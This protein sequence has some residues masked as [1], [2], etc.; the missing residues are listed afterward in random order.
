LSILQI[1]NLDISYKE[2]NILKNVNL[3]VEENEIISIMG[4][5]GSGKSTF[6][7]CLNGF[8]T[9]NGGQYS[10][11]ILFDGKDIS[12]YKLIDLRR[13]IS[14]LFQDSTVFD[15]SIEKNLTYTLEYFFRQKLRQKIKNRT[16]TQKRELVRRIKR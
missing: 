5:S 13:Q 11:Q 8:L 16:N 12:Q 7:S 14:M 4:N 9:E 6:L 1:N 2:K 15:M 3:T 10:G